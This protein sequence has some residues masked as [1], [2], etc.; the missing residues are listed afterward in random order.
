M[1]IEVWILYF[2]H[3]HNESSSFLHVCMKITIHD[4]TTRI[5]PPIFSHFLFISQ[6]A[7]SLVNDILDG[8]FNRTS[9]PIAQNSQP[10]DEVDV[11]NALDIQETSNIET[12]AFQSNTSQTGKSEEFPVEE[13]SSFQPFQSHDNPATKDGNKGLGGGLN[14]VEVEA[15]QKSDTVVPPVLSL[16][17]SFT[18]VIHLFREI[19]K[20]KLSK[21]FR[22]K[23]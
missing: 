20:M 1:C 17:S 8:S 22:G 21:V 9:E 6:N 5:W 12:T 14:I 19:K 4:N 11:S 3:T 18:I 23:A 13:S 16:V 2:L 10:N 7:A 15:H